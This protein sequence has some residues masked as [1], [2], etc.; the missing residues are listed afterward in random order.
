[1]NDSSSYSELYN[2]SVTDP[3]SFWQGQAEAIHWK[4]PF[5]DDEI[6]GQVIHCFAV[7]RQGSLKEEPELKN[8]IIQIILGRLGAIARPVAIHIVKQLPRTRSGKIVRRAIQAVVEEKPLGDLSTLED[9][10]ALEELKS[11]VAQSK[12]EELRAKVQNLAFSIWA[13]RVQGGGSYPGD[14]E[15]DGFAARNQLGVPPE[16]IL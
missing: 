12:M 6:K 10:T 5:L 8:E 4:T 2:W 13:R 9:Y 1:M 7:V 14:A 11:E 3:T 15:S 16:V